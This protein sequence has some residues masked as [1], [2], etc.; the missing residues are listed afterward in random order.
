MRAE[1]LPNNP[2]IRP[3]MDSRIG[4]NINGPSL[5]RTPDWVDDRLG[6]YYLYFAD[7][8]GDYIRLAYADALEGP[9][10]AHAPGTLQLRES[11][12]P[13]EKREL[14][15]A[16]P[17]SRRLI[18]DDWLP[19]HIA[20]PDVHVDR[21][22]R[23]V[24]MYFHGL[25]PDGQQRTRVAI[26][27]DGIHF[28]ALPEILT[29]SYLR[30]FSFEGW[31]YG[32]A[33]PGLLYRS[34]DGLTGFERGPNL[35]EP[36]MRHAALKRVEHELLVFWTRVGDDPERILCARIDLSGDWRSWKASEPEDVLSPE[37][38]WEGADLPPDPSVRGF[39][40]GRLRQLRDPGIFEENGRTYLLYAVAGESGIAIAE[41]HL[42]AV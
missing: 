2:I 35:F 24:R 4:S 14:A 1:R 28:E 29:L 6:R 34:A 12:F 39:A 41:L 25:L 8:R 22:E 19:P 5:V 40:P 26:S 23:R 9:W 21:A 17:V 42:D 20:S 11:R 7:H 31:Y 16:D 37:E 18:E 38:P 3:E 32:I 33:M 27:R 36:N 10:R 15:P 13:V 30:V